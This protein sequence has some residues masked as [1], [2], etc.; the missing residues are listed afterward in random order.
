MQEGC[1]SLWERTVLQWRGKKGGESGMPGTMLLCRREDKGKASHQRGTNKL[2]SWTWILFRQEVTSDRPT[3]FAASTATECPLG[4]RSKP[5]ER[6]SLL[7]LLIGTTP[8]AVYSKS[9]PLGAGYLYH[10][11]NKSMNYSICK[12]KDKLHQDAQATQN[13]KILW[14]DAKKWLDLKLVSYK[15]FHS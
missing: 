7:N 9:N 2:H 12:S 6:G 14:I 11:A 13:L 3:A 1:G 10:R 15:H 8:D 4:R 5:V